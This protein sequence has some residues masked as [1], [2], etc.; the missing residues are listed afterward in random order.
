MLSRDEEYQAA[1]NCDYDA[2]VMSQMAWVIRIASRV[3]TEFQY[4]D[5]EGLV[6][7]GAVGLSRAVRRFDPDRGFRL[8]TFTVR[9]IYWACHGEVMRNQSRC[10]PRNSKGRFIP[11]EL[12]GD[13]QPQVECAPECRLEPD[14]SGIVGKVLASLDSRKADVLRR[15]VDGDRLSDIAK[16]YGISRERVRQLK[17]RAIE[18]ARAKL[19]KFGYNSSV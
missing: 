4:E 7:A 12:W 2:L 10:S 18:E 11:T 13:E 15:W 1:R 5:I 16:E 14:E 3:A 9:P 8:T 6:S 17:E 19:I